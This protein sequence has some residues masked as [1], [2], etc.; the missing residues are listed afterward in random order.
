MA[1]PDGL[2]PDVVQFVND[3]VDSIEHALQRAAD[4][5]DRSEL[6][7]LQRR[8]TVL[9][10]QSRRY[11]VR[12]LLVADLRAVARS[13]V[14]RLSTLDPAEVRDTGGVVRQRVDC[15]DADVVAVDIV[16]MAWTVFNAHDPAPFLGGFLF[17]L[18]LARA[19][20]RIRARSN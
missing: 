18:G 4:P 11:G 15:W 14:L 16:F 2:P 12:P 8:D 1:V 7:A 17:S 5:A 9:S 6:A 13:A 20:R 10:V 3:T 19:A